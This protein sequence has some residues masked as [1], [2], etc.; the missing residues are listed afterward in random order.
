MEI[1]GIDQDTFYA[2]ALYL[3]AA[4][5][6]LEGRGWFR[7]P[8]TREDT[9][10]FLDRL[11]DCFARSKLWDAPDHVSATAMVKNEEQKKITLYI[12]KNRS[13]G[14]REASISENSG[15]VKHQTKNENEE[16]AEKLM[17]FSNDLTKRTSEDEETDDSKFDKPPA[18]LLEMC[19]FNRSRLEHYVKMISRLSIFD[20]ERALP[21]SLEDAK[22][23][24]QAQKNGWDATKSVINQCK[25]YQTKK[26][27][28]VGSNDK[29]FLC[30][31]FCATLAGQTH[32]THDFQC[33]MDKI[34]TSAPEFKLRCLLNPAVEGVKCL[35][36]IF[37]TFVAFSRFC[38]DANQCGYTF[39]YVL[40]RSQADEWIGCSYIRKIQSWTGDLGLYQTI[41]TQ[42]EEVVQKAKNTAPVHCEM[43]LMMYFLQPGAPA[44]EDYFG[45]SKKSCWLCWH[46]MVQNEKFSMK[47]THRKLYPRWAM[48]FNF[49]PSQPNIAEGL[50]IANNEMLSHLQHKVIKQTEFRA[51]G[52]CLQSS[53]R[54]TPRYA[55]AS[56]GTSLFSG[57]TIR[58]PVRICLMN[59]PA[60]YIPESASFDE[61][62]HVD[63]SVYLKQES[64]IPHLPFGSHKGI[65]F[66]TAFQL[67]T[68]ELQSAHE[69]PEEN[70]LAY[71]FW[72]D[73]I[74]LDAATDMKYYLW[75]RS[76]T[77][78]R[79][80]T[81]S[82]MKPNRCVQ[83]IWTRVHGQ[84]YYDF[85]W[86]GDVFVFKG[87]EGPPILDLQNLHT[88]DKSAFFNSLVK[89]FKF[90]GDGYST[91]TMK[92]NQEIT[93][94][95]SK[96]TR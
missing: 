80:K 56:S 79:S 87:S 92:R 64:R 11:A 43:Q 29:E 8:F 74:I 52:P 61:V 17:D 95:S 59:V 10:D 25:D 50:A 78:R 31:V 76:A 45:C 32:K 18:F 24:D 13:Y 16:F 69:I 20:L 88:A 15:A 94:Y 96:L 34:E 55:N 39:S 49:S 44:C 73:D 30:L 41:R 9:R 67:A 26:S 2:A 40:L 6:E 57:G 22:G 14:H 54:Q 58:V 84:E 47:D 90:A 33:F 7:G 53:A 51:L 37:S 63:V 66:V 62:Q 82:A 85:P 5:G 86:R 81:G 3:H 1:P 12:A 75:Y 71:R 21:V 35:G 48:P 19:K 27:E 65:D 77:Q 93:A 72:V 89:N 38:K 68:E 83:E 70:E 36:R 42:M 91:E 23:L 28:M 46:M 4:V 60:L